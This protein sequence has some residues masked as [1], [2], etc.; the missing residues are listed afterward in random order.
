[1]HWSQFTWV[2]QSVQQFLMCA[3]DCHFK[4]YHVV[5]TWLPCVSL[6]YIFF[7][8]LQWWLDGQPTAEFVVPWCSFSFKAHRSNMNG[9]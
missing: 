3:P 7:L 2:A 6:K 1:M 8:L 5:I 9:T 4:L